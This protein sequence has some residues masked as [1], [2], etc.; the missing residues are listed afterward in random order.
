MGSGHEAE[1]FQIHD[2]PTFEIFVK[3]SDNGSFGGAKLNG[4]NFRKWKRLIAAHLRGMHKMGHVTGVTEN[5][6]FEKLYHG[7]GEMSESIDMVTGSVEITNVSAT[8]TP[9]D[10]VTPEIQKEKVPYTFYI[11]DKELNESLGEYA[12]KIKNSGE[13]LGSILFTIKSII[14]VT[15]GHSEA[16]FSVAYSPDGMQL[17]SGSGD[18]TV[19][20]WDL[21]TQTPLYT[22][23]GHKN[24]VLCIAWS[25]DGKH[26]LVGA[27]LENFRIGIRSSVHLIVDTAP[28]FSKITVTCCHTKNRIEY[29]AM[30]AMDGLT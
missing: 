28:I 9:P 20:L 12:E 14:F 7:E 29:L 5:S 19:R 4:T 26:P 13:K 10:V 30:K 6:H 2:V 17:A 18:T 21:N 1:G 27:S 22:C 23:S 11:A 8:Q 25:A 24:W 16:V 15:A 3:G